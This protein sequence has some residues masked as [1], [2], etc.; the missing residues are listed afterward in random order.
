M[1]IID[2][3]IIVS[4]ARGI[5]KHSKASQQLLDKIREKYAVVLMP[6]ISIIEITSALFRSTQDVN[7]TEE[8][9]DSIRRLPNFIF[10]PIDRALTDKSVRVILATG[11]RSADA[12]YVAL[13]HMYGLTLFT[14]DKEQLEKGALVA[15][16]SLPDSI[17]NM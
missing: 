9:V 6:E 13:A 8:F 11:L 4:A 3:S 10:T 17:D 1:I 16:T 5:E 14:L 2:A 12:I 7:F 15:K